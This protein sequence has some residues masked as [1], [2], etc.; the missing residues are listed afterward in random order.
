[1]PGV[2]AA[3]CA[4]GTLGGW[5]RHQVPIRVRDSNGVL[6]AASGDTSWC[7]RYAERPRAANLCEAW[8]TQ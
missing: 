8:V 4:C 5:R 6:T 7:P 3:Y 2:A 1:M